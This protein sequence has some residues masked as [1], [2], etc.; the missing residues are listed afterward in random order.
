MEIKAFNT[1]IFTIYDK[2]WALAAAGTM[3]SHNA[4]TVSWGGMGTLWNKPVVTIYVRP[5]R[6]TRE[7]T[8]R[9]EY[10]TVSF[11]DEKYREALNV[12][13]TRSGRDCDKEAEAGLTAVPMGESVTFKEAKRT[14]LCRKLYY[15]DLDPAGMAKEVQDKQYPGKD[16]HRMYIGEVIEIR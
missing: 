13:G 2:D 16:F 4:M 8:E 9:E 7:F 1:D 3:E 5:S 15:Q 12:M 11:Y 6:Y 14:L 10:F